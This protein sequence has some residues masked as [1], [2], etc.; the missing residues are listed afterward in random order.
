MQIQ[1][2]NNPWTKSLIWTRR[3]KETTKMEAKRKPETSISVTMAPQK[4]SI[5]K[6]YIW[7]PMPVCITTRML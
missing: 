5:K 1:D 6:F 2:E 7:S 4:R 3:V